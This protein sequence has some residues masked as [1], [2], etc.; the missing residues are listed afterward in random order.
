MNTTIAR[1]PELRRSVDCFVDVPELVGAKSAAAIKEAV[2]EL[3]SLSARAQY[4][5]PSAAQTDFYKERARMMDAGEL[6]HE[7]VVKLG[8]AESWVKNY[9]DSGGM[10]T[11]AGARRRVVAYRQFRP[12]Y[13]KIEA[14]LA[15]RQKAASKGEAELAE[16]AGVPYAPS[17]GVQS[18]SDTLAVLR[19]RLK[20]ADDDPSNAPHLA[21]Y[22]AAILK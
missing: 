2:E 21:E 20:R 4:Y 8:T 9:A 13:G 1:N 15:A 12:L 10:L 18:L 3:K 11:E 16:A 19:A 6:S 17:S 5:T 14:A 7:Q 22:F